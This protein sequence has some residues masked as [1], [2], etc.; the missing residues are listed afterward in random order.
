MKKEI[1][2]CIPCYNEQDNIIPMVSGIKNL[3]ESELQ[4]YDYRIV[5]IDNKSTDSTREMIKQVCN[6]D[7]RVKAIFNIKNFKGESGYYGLINAGGDCTISI[8]ADFQ[9]PLD[10]I[11]RLVKKWENGSAIVCAVKESTKSNP[12]M[13]CIRQRYYKILDFFADNEVIQNFTGAGL[14][15]NKFIDFLRNLNDPIPS[16]LQ[17]IMTHGWNVEKEYYV[18]NRRKSGKSHHSFV[19]LLNIGIVRITNA[20]TMFPRMTTFCGII[21]GFLVIIAAL[22]YIVINMFGGV[23]FTPGVLP[24]LLGVFFVGSVQLVFLG[25]ISE[26]IM[27]INIRVM[28][29]PLVIEEERINF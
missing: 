27:K 4:E 16:L 25:M 11:P 18:E 3:F 5:F 14:Y 9:V 8:P 24:I 10:I 15:D 28:N 21:M 20:S 12:I 13:W 26:Y 19:D 23:G 22:I 1:G 7:C 6:E 29:R 2:I 17:L